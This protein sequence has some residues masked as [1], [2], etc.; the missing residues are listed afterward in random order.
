MG[1]EAVMLAFVFHIQAEVEECLFFFLEENIYIY[2][3]RGEN[4]YGN[5]GKTNG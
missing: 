2:L 4:I 1:H 5:S 3:S